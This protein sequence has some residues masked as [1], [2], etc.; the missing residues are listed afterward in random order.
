MEI[1]L[2]D[3]TTQLDEN[4]TTRQ[5]NIFGWKHHRALAKTSMVEQQQQ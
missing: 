3:E 4:K 5:N 1:A 2:L